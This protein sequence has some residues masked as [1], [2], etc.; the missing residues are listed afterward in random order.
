MKKATLIIL[1]LLF[2]CV[3]ASLAQAGT[4]VLKNQSTTVKAAVKNITTKSTSAAVKLTAYDNANT[5]IGSLCKTVYLSA[6]R[7]TSVDFSWK[8]PNYATGVYWSSKV[9]ANK[10]CPSVP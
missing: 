7:T 10:P 1:T 4:Q 9:E 8:S 5:K 3:T 2:T 6:G